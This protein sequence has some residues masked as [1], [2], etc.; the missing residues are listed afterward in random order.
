MT[1]WPCPDPLCGGTSLEFASTRAFQAR[2][3]NR[4]DRVYLRCP[5]CEGSFMTEREE[6]EKTFWK[7]AP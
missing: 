5:R 6:A 1:R 3:D 7:D 2:V 4:R